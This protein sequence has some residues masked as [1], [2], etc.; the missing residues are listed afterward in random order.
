MISG[1]RLKKKIAPLAA[2]LEA[3]SHTYR[4]SILWLLAHDSLEPRDISRLLGIPSNLTAFHLDLLH[5]YG[6]I[7]KIKVG[8][9]VTYT[10]EKKAFLQF[11]NLFKSTSLGEE[12]LD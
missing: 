12:K 9:S 3:A 8:R 7:T 5:R 6:W 10:L 1:I 4:L 2:K 11:I